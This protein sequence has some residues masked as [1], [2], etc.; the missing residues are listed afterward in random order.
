M[1]DYANYNQL[2]Y[3]K[4]TGSQWVEVD[5]YADWDKDLI[6]LK[7]NW[8]NTGVNQMILSFGGTEAKSGWLYS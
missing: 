6:K 2:S 8:T 5:F 1:F 4:A 3:L 7:C